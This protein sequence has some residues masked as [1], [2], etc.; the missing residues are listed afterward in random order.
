MLLRVLQYHLFSLSLHRSVHTNVSYTGMM[1][2]LKGFKSPKLIVIL[3]IYVQIVSR[4]ACRHFVLCKVAGKTEH[5][6]SC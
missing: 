4:I 3:N 5:F 2:T 6:H 1:V